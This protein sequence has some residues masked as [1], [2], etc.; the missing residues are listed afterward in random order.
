MSLLYCHLPASH[1]WPARGHLGGKLKD[2]FRRKIKVWRG[3]K[4]AA[5][6]ATVAN[7][8]GHHHSLAQNHVWIL[9]D[10]SQKGGERKNYWT[11]CLR[12]QRVW[13]SDVFLRWIFFS[14]PVCNF[15]TGTWGLPRAVQ[16]YHLKW[17]MSGDHWKD[18]IRTI[19]PSVSLFADL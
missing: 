6:Q 4:K 10:P 9:L 19:L 14:V 13:P 16:A 5:A 11:L 7:W 18:N 2:I 3:C 8:Q 17:T 1:K 12:G 15:T